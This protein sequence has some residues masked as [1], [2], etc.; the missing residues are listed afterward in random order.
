MNNKIKIPLTVT[1]LFFSTYFYSQNHAFSLLEQRLSDLRNESN[2]IE[3]QR[4]DLSKK[5]EYLKSENKRLKSKDLASKKELENNESKLEE[6]IKKLYDTQN[7]LLLKIAEASVLAQQVALL[8]TANDTLANQVK[9]L[10][11]TKAILEKSLNSTKKRLDSVENEYSEID[12]SAKIRSIE[13][14]LSNPR[15]YHAK[16]FSVFLCDG[17]FNVGQG[18]SVHASTYMYLV[19]TRS[20]MLGL[21]IGYDNYSEK[22]D[23][24]QENFSLIP[25]AFSWRGTLNSRDFF[26]YAKDLESFNFNVYYVLNAGAAFTIRDTEPSK[27][28]NGNALFNIG[29][30]IAKPLSKTVAFSLSASLGSQRLL[31]SDVNKKKSG[32]NRFMVALKAGFFFK[33]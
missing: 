8:K 33:K 1:F 15:G 10:Q 25:I 3:K 21:N 12:K 11:A 23:V 16:R 17:G 4:N 28:V 13:N 18:F 31:I 19:P 7:N 29:L 22:L 14:S 27:N 2:A 9:D 32:D 30:G 5:V 24:T 26:S 6:T 20:I